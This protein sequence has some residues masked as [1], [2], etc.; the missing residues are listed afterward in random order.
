MPITS[1]KADAGHEDEECESDTSLEDESESLEDEDQGQ[2]NLEGEITEDETAPLT[3]RGLQRYQYRTGWSTNVALIGEIQD[4]TVNEA[5]KDHKWKRE[6][7][8]EFNSLTQ[9]KTWKLVKCPEGV[10]PLTCR[11]VLYEKADGRLKAHPVARGFAQEEG[12]DYTETFSPENHTCSLWYQDSFP[13][14]Q[15]GG[16][17]LHASTRRVWR[18]HELCLQS[19]ERIIW[20]ETGCEEMTWYDLKIP[21]EAN[22]STEHRSWW[23]L[24]IL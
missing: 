14:R 20:T 18:W 19:T 16:G 17:N 1:G 2:G 13:I 8:E 12:I 21:W 9:M 10:R 5:L 4:I 7:Q 24:F 3:R 23:S 22:R 6:M 11:W 15:S